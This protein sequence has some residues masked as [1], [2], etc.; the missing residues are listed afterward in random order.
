MIQA[1]MIGAGASGIGAYGGYALKHPEQIRFVAV[2]DP[3]PDAAGL[4]RDA[5]PDSRGD[6]NLRPTREILA[7]PKLADACFLCTQDA[8][9]LR[10][11]DAGDARRAII[12]FWKSRWRFR[13]AT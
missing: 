8:P 4:F 9:A 5:A 11:G 10:T 7:V 13:R 3:D 1:I 12:C 2:A 6:R